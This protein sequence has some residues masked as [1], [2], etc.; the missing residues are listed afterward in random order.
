MLRRIDTGFLG[1]TSERG[2][3]RDQV[4]DEVVCI[5]DRRTLL[6]LLH[7]RAPIL[8][9]CRQ[10]SQFCEQKPRSATAFHR[11]KILMPL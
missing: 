2:I 5:D 4:G 9:A 11:I 10:V 6:A 3:Y 8:S 1:W 7:M